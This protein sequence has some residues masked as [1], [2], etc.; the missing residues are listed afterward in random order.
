MKNLDTNLLKKFK[1]K[2]LSDDFKNARIIYRVKGGVPTERIE[3]EVLVN[4]DGKVETIINEDQL[5]VL[6]KGK[7]SITR[8]DDEIKNLF[9]EVTN[10][11][12]QLAAD[13]SK[14]LPDSIIGSISIQ[15]EDKETT[16]G[17]FLPEEEDRKVQN[18]FVGPNF[19]NVINKLESFFQEDG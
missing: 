12:D 13:D 17:Y 18:K 19:S 10:F 15:I 11:I 3:K 6:S 16:I 8:K 2:I 7:K 14:F 5:G 9:K 4:A 1:S